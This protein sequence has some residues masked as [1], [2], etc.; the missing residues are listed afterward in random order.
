MSSKN[1]PARIS[2]PSGFPEVLRKHVAVV[3][4]TGVLSL[5]ERKISN[6]LLL[7]AYDD[8]VAPDGLADP[9]HTIPL[10]YL[11]SLV[12]WEDSRNLNALKVAIRSLQTTTLEFDLMEETNDPGWESMSMLSYAKIVDGTCVYGYI[13]EL[14]Q[15]LH[16]PDVFALINVGV[17]RTLKG[18]YALA[19]YEN[20]VRFRRTK[21]TG[22]WD[23]QKFRR[24]VGADASMYDE[25][26]RLSAFVIKRAIDEINASSDI[27]LVVEYQ[28]SGRKVVALR[29]LIEENPQGSLFGPNPLDTDEIAAIRG[30]QTYAKL[31]SH[32]IGERLALATMRQD[33][34]LARRAVEVAEAKDAQG[35]I[36]TSTG[37]YI[38]TLIDVKAELGPTAYQQQKVA[39]A[40]EAKLAHKT[41]AAKDRLDQLE[42]EYR[43]QQAR[44]WAKGL[45]SDIVAAKA[46]D[47]VA[48]GNAKG[49]EFDETKGKF[50]RQTA[51]ISFRQWLL[52]SAPIDLGG[53]DEFITSKRIDPARLRADARAT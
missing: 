30:S 48:T 47:F 31:R 22:W 3:H 6:V 19:L 40:T 34:E 52:K 1:L 28:R 35:L 53:L 25:F 4:S 41:A 39:R 49:S 38:K 18:A 12:G 14:A 26:K 16:D 11:A 8:L 23:L 24:L 7:N 17:Q 46:V 10:R 44:A 43:D 13:K 9:R 21:S 20:C 32:G 50:D 5:V 27:S 2:P 51:Q 33:P 42:A 37:A 29:F 36:K 15:R 45:G